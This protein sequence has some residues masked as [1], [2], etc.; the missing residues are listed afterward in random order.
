[1]TALINLLAAGE[2][3]ADKLAL[4][5]AAVVVFGVTAQWIANQLNIPAILLLL[6]AG[7]L[8]GPV[9]GIIEPDELLGN[10][11]FPAVSLA[12]GILLFEGGL[13]LKYGDIRVGQDVVVRLVTIGVVI[14]WIV[15]AISARLLF[16][17]S[18][19]MAV[20][21]GS[22]LVVSGPTVVLPLVRQARPRDPTASILK[23]EG[24]VIDPI[25]ATVAIVALD[26][27]LT[28][29]GSILNSALRV[30]TTAGVGLASGVIGALVLV[31]A[32]RR[33]LVADRL[34]NPF[35]LMIVVAAFEA[36][37]LLR[38]E[39]GLF[40]TT[41][42]GV[43]LANQRRAPIRH[44]QEFEENL[45]ILIIAALFILLAARIE[46]EALS[47][48]WV[49]SI[50][51][52]AILV[53]IA[54]PLAVYF[55]TV[56]ASLPGNHRKYLCCLAPRG[57]VAAAVS[58]VFALELEAEGFAVEADPIVPVTFMVIVG[59]VLVY[60]T[61]ASPLAQRLRVARPKP[62]GV[63]LIGGEDWA[64]ELGSKL[65]EEH[66]DV[67]IVATDPDEVIS[68][69]ERGMLAYG[70]RLDSEDLDLALDAVGIAQAIALSR[71]SD[72]NAFGMTRLVERLGRA[73]VFHLPP[74][75]DESGQESSTSTSVYGRRPF[76]PAATQA[77]I[78]RAL[79]A[80]GEFIT[81][82]EDSFDDELMTNALPLITIGPDKVPVISMSS[83]PARPAPGYR[84]IMLSNADAVTGAPT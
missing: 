74:T 66:V 46:L 69:A 80:G 55:S 75:I 3:G 72:L 51:L 45:G 67:L 63:A 53:F 68:A 24:I 82:D 47:A 11:L 7:V 50:V 37:N 61:M 58:S 25:G 27:V 64:L 5:L 14:T 35:T 1:M 54:R 65:I 84:T 41:V 49:R 48:Y 59:T 44:I 10:L 21:I 12:V 4:A 29:D 39:A 70:G 13:D 18:N 73:R 9:T 33:H 23:W 38:P 19:R 36:A 32:L 20:L 62:L 16:D 77:R 2:A 76:S 31:E 42:M 57:I 34:H 71:T 15:A 40:A 52:V 43:I 56:G 22:L 60:G 28:R 81:V 78:Q 17:T 83:A 6:P 26:A 8:A 79:E 30:L